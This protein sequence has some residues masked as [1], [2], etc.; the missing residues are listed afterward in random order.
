MAQGQCRGGFAC[1]CSICEGVVRIER[2]SFAAAK[3]DNENNTEINEMIY[4]GISRD[5]FWFMNQ[6]IT[7]SDKLR[8]CELIFPDTVFFKN[9]KPV[10]VVKSDPRDFC[11]MGI[12]HPK[13]LSLASLY[14]DFQ[15]VVRKRKKDYVGPFGRLYF[16][17]GINR[18][19]L[20]PSSSVGGNRFAS[21]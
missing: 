3:V 2:R 9:G 8:G 15:N 1:N 12:R 21:L 4:E 20:S 5:F 10:L 14:K 16:K 18:G 17:K 7:Q 19:G 6:L 13:K 11:L